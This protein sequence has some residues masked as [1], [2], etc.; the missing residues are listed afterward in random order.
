MNSDIRDILLQA[1]ELQEEQ[2]RIEEDTDSLHNFEEKE[3]SSQELEAIALE[4]GIAPKFVT[5]A[6]VMHSKGFR[7]SQR[8]SRFIGRST[9]INQ[10]LVL[11][12]KLT[13]EELEHLNTMLTH[14]F[15]SGGSGTVDSMGLFWKS[16]PPSYFQSQYVGPSSLPLSG[17]EVTISF[18]QNRTII[19]VT[20]H[21]VQ[22][23]FGIFGGILGGLGIGLGVGVGVGV[24]LGALGSSL[25]ALVFPPLAFLG[26]YGLARGIYTR[27][28]ENQKKQ[29]TELKQDLFR[30][31]SLSA[32]QNLQIGNTDTTD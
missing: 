30:F 4:A 25:F 26:A 29:L 2:E 19:Q 21:L 18:S 14:R 13:Q 8:P 3:L 15:Q 28:Y 5:Q 32:P 10:W 27:L 1:L 12:R 16:H 22:D 11:D 17:R 9:Q 24:G 6:L 7:Q 31:N 20:Q 23:A